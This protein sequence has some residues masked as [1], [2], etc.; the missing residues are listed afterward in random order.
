MTPKIRKTKFKQQ[1]EN[2]LTLMIL[3]THCLYLY[4]V[5]MTPVQERKERKKERK[6]KKKKKKT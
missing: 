1:H 2:I 5:H 4:K 3:T 6:E